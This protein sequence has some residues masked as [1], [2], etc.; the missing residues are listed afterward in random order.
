MPNL[1]DR[2][3][4]IKLSVE[5]KQVEI[6][7]LG[8]VGIRKMTL[9]DRMAWVEAG[10]KGGVVLIK[11]TVCDPESGELSLK[12][13]SDD[14]LLELPTEVADALLEEIVSHNGL[15]KKAQ[16]SEE[17]KNLEANQN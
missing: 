7:G 17:L 12:E 8:L 11:R 14:D 5:P 10:N 4:Q 16:E 6:D 13:M 3:Q 1:K 9:A 15:N 2:I